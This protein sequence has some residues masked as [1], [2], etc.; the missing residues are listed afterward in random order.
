MGDPRLPGARL[1][2]PVVGVQA[3]NRCQGTEAGRPPHPLISVPHPMTI[4]QRTCVALS[5]D[6]EGSPGG[7]RSHDSRLGTGELG[8]H[9]QVSEPKVGSPAG[10]EGALRQRRGGRTLLVECSI[11]RFLI[12]LKP[13]VVRP[14]AVLHT[15]LQEDNQVADSGSLVRRG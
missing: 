3:E 10:E 1:C 2:H 15:H 7:W 8:V 5:A 4:A 11:L 6:G 12:P 9:L 14:H 13:S